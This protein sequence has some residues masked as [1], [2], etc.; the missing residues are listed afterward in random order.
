[1]AD[2]HERWPGVR[3][4]PEALDLFCRRFGVAP[5]DAAAMMDA[6][7][8]ADNAELG[9][10]WRAYRALHQVEDAALELALLLGNTPA[11]AR[12]VARRA[13]SEAISRAPS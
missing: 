10:A 5:A 12:E 9:L 1:M 7:N 6:D 11:R 4:A 3:F 8:A 13:R 2:R